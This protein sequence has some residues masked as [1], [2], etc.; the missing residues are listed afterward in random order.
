MVGGPDLDVENEGDII[1]ARATSFYLLGEE[2]GTY[3]FLFPYSDLICTILPVHR[4]CDD[5]VYT[6]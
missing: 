6:L 3:H 1:Q 4:L 2:D 5:S